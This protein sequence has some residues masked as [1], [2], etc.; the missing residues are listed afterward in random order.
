MNTQRQTNT[1]V[2]GLNTDSDYSV[3]DSAQYQWAENV[4]VVANEGSSFATLQNIEGVIK[5]NPTLSPQDEIVYVTTIRD[6]AIV[7]T[8][9]TSGLFGVY[10]YDFS[11][12]ETE[13]EVALVL[14]PLALDIPCIDGVYPI[15][16]V[17]RWESENNVKIYFADGEHQIR[18]LNV[19]EAHEKTITSVD[20]LN[21]LPNGILPPVEIYGVG[22]GSLK[23]GYYQYCYQLFNERSNT[24]NISVLSGMFRV[25][26]DDSK[27]SSQTVVGSTYEE[28]TGKSLKFG[29]ELLKGDFNRAKIYQIYYKDNTSVPTITL[30]EDSVV[31]GTALTYEDKGGYYLSELTVDEFNALTTYDF[32][33]HI[34]ASLD[35]ILFAANVT[36]NTWDV[37][38]DEYDTRAYRCNTDGKVT[39]K[40]NTEAD[41]T[42]NI[43]D[44]DTTKVP[45]TYDCICP[46]NNLTD[47]DSATYKYKPS[48]EGYILG[49]KG[50]NIEYEFITADLIEDGEP[51]ASDG[52]LA[53]TWKLNVDACQFS[54][55][56][57][58]R[59]SSSKTQVDKVTFK[60]NSAKIPNYCNAEIDAKLRGYHRDEIYRFGIVFYNAKNEASP[61]HWI[62][63]IRMPRFSDSVP[64]EC[65]V[66]VTNLDSTNFKSLV[67][68]PLGVRFTVN[69][70]RLP[71]TVTGFEIVRCDRTP[72]D[73]SIL[74]QGVISNITQNSSWNSI[75]TP[76]PYLSYST[77]HCLMSTSS[78][79][80]YMWK[81]SKTHATNETASYVQFISPELCVNRDG[82]SEVLESATTVESIANLQS[83]FT[84]TP[85]S[86][87]GSYFYNGGYSGSKVRSMICAKQVIK[88]SEYGVSALG[89]GI[90]AYNDESL[91]NDGWV[92]QT[93]NFKSDGDK[94]GVNSDDGDSFSGNNVLRIDANAY[95]HNTALGK[96]YFNS[97]SS[98]STMGT[99]SVDDITYAGECESFDFDD[100]SWKAKS[101]AVGN[102]T[103]VNWCWTNA[104]TSKN[105]DDNNTRKVGPHGICAILYSKDLYTNCPLINS[106]SSL[107]NT[108]AIKLC[109]LKQAVTAYG[110]ESYSARQNST[111]I[112]TG[113]YRA[114]S[115]Q[116]DSLPCFGGDTFIGIM[117]YA[118]CTMGFHADH[119]LA[120]NECNRAYVGAYIPFETSVNL[121]LRSD[122]SQVSR[123]LTTNGYAN[124]LVQNN[125]CQLGTLY[126]QNT[127]LYAYND[128]Y[129]ARPNV[130]EFVSKSMYNI[131][132]QHTDTRI[133]ASEKK[134]ND[135]V[136]DSWSTFKVAN[137]ID[138]DTR[139]GSINN[140]KS[141][142]NTLFFWQTDAFGTV[143]VND[144]SLI[145]DN[146]IGALTLG[147]GD[148][149]SRFDYITTLN[150]SRANHLRNTVGSDS[151]LYWFDADRNEIC[152]F[153]QMVNSLSKQ[154]F[155]QSYLNRVKDDMNNDPTAVY[156]K[157][158]NEVLFTL[159]DNTLVYSEPLQAFTSVYT[160]RP[161]HWIDFT[162]KLYIFKI[163]SLFKYNAGDDM[164]LFTGK[165]KVS[166]IKFVVSANYPQ[167]KTF[168]NVEYAGDFTYGTNFDN[169][170]FET[171]RQT[172]GILNHNSID[173]RE[174]TY[175]FCIP[176]N[177]ATLNVAE[178]I[179]NKTYRD[180]MKGKYLVCNYK[181]DCN[182]GNTFKVPYISTSYRASLI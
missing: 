122:E 43:A 31:T 104:D 123:T 87:D 18:V 42:F 21:I 54:E 127:P 96:Y 178:Q 70:S 95:A 99:A 102:K 3:I 177:R 59:V 53:E 57:L 1:F 29:T 171:K 56:P 37:E 115:E 24:T 63:D 150:G 23:A 153:A 119:W 160:F 166:T 61:V 36:E 92:Y 50:K 41:I 25:S 74:M 67:T 163:N 17:C 148:V 175:K 62:A 4:R 118:V 13:P 98:T 147:T 144:R 28:N 156:D 39:I 9:T 117:D 149:L 145:Q 134:T 5:T 101:V 165:D 66:K 142:N 136:I 106:T 79:Y 15:S 111:Y 128:A 91:R 49:G 137:Y 131:D 81:Y 138:V 124:Y 174:D 155:V 6:W 78:K 139:Y 158:Y 14:S 116:N 7:F 103:Y 108:V 47:T 168:D 16:S 85:I 90:S 110:G 94:D 93:A 34:L 109:N 143:S 22:S 157:K 161:D 32:A 26:K 60:D 73:R 68:H 10:R 76:F 46:Y 40:S 133:L 162:D 176:R 19:D 72:E 164:N 172:S 88:L 170:Y 51:M 69:T 27:T 132:N 55:L 77:R 65:G 2:K 146:N 75:M 121:S 152:S 45:T 180:R 151:A 97:G 83:N 135:E 48:D 12:S 114:I 126:S 33:P 64:F 105:T 80:R 140:M 52:L 20:S 44:V 125:I 86:G 167:T 84:T 30:I 159:E 141:Y 154:K 35:N 181:Y 169:I 107:A 89:G 120:D 11:R 129:S 130:K 38:E 182:G 8:K 112:S 113:L 179:A 100:D 71:D 173:Y 82:A 58:Y